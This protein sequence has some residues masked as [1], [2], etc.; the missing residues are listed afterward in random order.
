MRAFGLDRSSGIRH[1]RAVV[2]TDPPLPASPDNGTVTISWS[3]TTIQGQHRLGWHYQSDPLLDPRLAIA[4]LR[5][6]ASELEMDL[7]S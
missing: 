1:Y 5:D 2:A 6:V 7:P 4:L 3:T